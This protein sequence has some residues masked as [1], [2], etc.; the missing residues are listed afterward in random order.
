MFLNAWG[1]E[2]MASLSL[3]SVL[4]DAFTWGGGVLWT[5]SDACLGV[6]RSFPGDGQADA[7]FL[8]CEEA[9]DLLLRILTSS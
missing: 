9:L 7:Y 5:P 8:F 2:V 4:V 3:S 6:S 1:Y